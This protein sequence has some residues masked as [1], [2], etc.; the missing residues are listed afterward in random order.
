MLCAKLRC[1]K[2]FDSKA[3]SFKIGD[4]FVAFRVQGSGFRVLGTWF[5][6]QGSGYMVQGSGF[7]V[8]GTWLRVEGV[9][10]CV[11]VNVCRSEEHTSELQSR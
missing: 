9:C 10:V 6:V 3:F 7:R 8:Q 5:R 2:V 11:C 4:Y 1:Q